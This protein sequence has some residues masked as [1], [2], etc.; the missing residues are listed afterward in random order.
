MNYAI[1]DAWRTK[2]EEIKYFFEFLSDLN[3]FSSSTL[4]TFFYETQN[5]FI[6]KWWILWFQLTDFN[7]VL[8]YADKKNNR[9]LCHK[10]T[11]FIIIIT[12]ARPIVC[13]K[14]VLGHTL[15]NFTPTS[16]IELYMSC[17]AIKNTIHTQSRR[18]QWELHTYMFASTR[19]LSSLLMYISY[20]YTII[21]KRM[22]IYIYRHFDICTMSLY[23]S[24]P[25]YI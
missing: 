15:N 18:R 16:E 22:Y 12:K 4:M 8:S 1:I 10:F 14:K 11:I 17:I 24:S 2:C 19:Q 6:P 20:Y 3:F 5:Y 23:S 9:T 25:K 21:C 7:H 13:H